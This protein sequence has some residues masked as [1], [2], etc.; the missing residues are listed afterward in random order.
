MKDIFTQK[1]LVEIECVA[2][3]TRNKTSFY[4]FQNP[5]SSAWRLE[6]LKYPGRR[7]WK[8]VLKHIKEI[9]SLEKLKSLIKLWE[10]IYCV[11]Y[12]LVQSDI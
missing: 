4:N 8:M 5:S 6:S 7:L 9:P 2:N 12:M 10:T 3:N 11:T 1:D